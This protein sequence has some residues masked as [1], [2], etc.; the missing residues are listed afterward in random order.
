MEPSLAGCQQS[1]RPDSEGLMTLKAVR[2][3]VAGWGRQVGQRLL[4]RISLEG[5]G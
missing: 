1:G 3:R 5:S 2:G 4:G